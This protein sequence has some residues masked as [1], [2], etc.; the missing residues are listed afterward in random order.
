MKWFLLLLIATTG[1]QYGY[2]Q[3]LLYTKNRG[4]LK[5]KVAEISD[6]FVK[7]KLADVGEDVLYTTTKRYIDS[8]VFQNGM[9]QRFTEPSKHEK[10]KRRS[11]DEEFRNA[12]T[13]GISGGI[14]AFGNDVNSYKFGEGEPLKNPYTFATYIK[15][16][17]DILRKRVSVYVAPFIGLNKK[18]Y[19][20]ALG[21]SFNIKR[22]GKFNIG[23]GPEY[24]L[25][26]QDVAERFYTYN[27]DYGNFDYYKK[28][29][30]AVSYMSFIVNMKMNINQNLFINSNA[31]VGGIIGSS[32]RRYHLPSG[33]GYNNGTVGNFKLGLGYNF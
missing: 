11:K 27:A 21:A 33:G 28:Y 2:A 20:G 12:T 19:G 30:S 7:Y 22:F 24:H 26:V 3:D 31:G 15:Y 18:A 8:I 9:V 1:C 6:A 5:V 32:K 14:W 10:F 25:S 13:N 29:N 23:V 4:V 16:Q 17:K